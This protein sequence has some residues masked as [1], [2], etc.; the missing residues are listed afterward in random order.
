MKRLFSTI[1]LAVCVFAAANAQTSLAGRVYHHP[2]IMAD[3][4]KAEMG[5]IDKKI[6]EAKT[7]AFAKAA[8]EKGRALTADEK[9]KIEKEAD[10][11]AKMADAMMKGTKT[12][13]TVTF[14]TDKAMEM[15]MKLHIDEEAMKNAGI[16]WAKRKAIKAAIAVMPTTEKMQYT[17]KDNLIICSDGKEKDTLTVSSDGKYLYG[18]MDE[19]TKFKL[20]RTK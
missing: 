11:A 2:N 14:K 12:A 16:G 7:E 3:V 1:I 19:K 15:Q 5:D 17:V 20:T 9:A 13:I 4:M 10:E 6:A 18:K 8:K